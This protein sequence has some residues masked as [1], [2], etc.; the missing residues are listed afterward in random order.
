MTRPAEH[1]SNS[2]ARTQ[3][4]VPTSIGET[5][6]EPVHCPY[7]D[8]PFPRA[9]LRDLHVGDHHGDS[10]TEAEAEQ[11][12]AAVDRESDE[13]FVLHLKVIGGLV[14]AFFAIAYLYVF[15]LT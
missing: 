11:Y 12:E 15:I 2:P 14:L 5:D 7:C 4:T 10:M 8:R 6:V 1:S 3:G 9:H 13:L